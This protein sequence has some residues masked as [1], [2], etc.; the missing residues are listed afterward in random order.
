MSELYP[1]FNSEDEAGF[2]PV[3]ILRAE[4]GH[5]A[6]RHGL[7]YGRESWLHYRYGAEDE[8][9]RYEPTHVSKEVLV[10]LLP[11][12]KDDTVIRITTKEMYDFQGET[13]WI[14]GTKWVP[15]EKALQWLVFDA[16][17]LHAG[18]AHYNIGMVNKTDDP[19]Q[20]RTILPFF[21]IR[22]GKIITSSNYSVRPRISTLKRKNNNLVYPFGSPAH[23]SDVLHTVDLC[24]DILD[25][26]GSKVPQHTSVSDN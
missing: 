8:N 5:L 6:V 24:M 18:N 21:N 7:P 11:D 10:R 19:K 14:D 17:V 12:Q 13:R 26:I 20:E 9:G 25:E 23:P 4:V 15:R 1:H 2:S 16:T 22:E 3:D